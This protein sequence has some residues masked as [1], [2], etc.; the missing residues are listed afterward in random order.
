MSR[1][2]MRDA[3][4]LIR[5]NLERSVPRRG[6]TALQLGLCTVMLPLTQVSVP[7]RGNTALQLI[8]NVKAITDIVF[9]SPGGEIL[10][11]NEMKAGIIAVHHT[12]QSPRGEV[13]HCN[14]YR[15][16]DP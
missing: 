1:F 8:D 7:R 3:V 4:T 2:W 15:Y 5:P 12:F 10:R 13:L 9:Q 11:C 16:H 14:S 6:S